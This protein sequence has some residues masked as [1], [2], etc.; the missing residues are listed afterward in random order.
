MAGHTATD[1]P[2]AQADSIARETSLEIAH[3]TY[4]PGSSLAD[5][6]QRALRFL[7]E[8]HTHACEIKGHPE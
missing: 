4:V 7:K 6:R 3:A 2:A 1:I 8:K 5:W